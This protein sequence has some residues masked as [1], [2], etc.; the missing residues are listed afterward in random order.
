VYPY[1]GIP[2]LGHEEDRTLLLPLCLI[3]SENGEVMEEGRL[4]TSFGAFLRRF[5][6]EQPLRSPTI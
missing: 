6:Y 5:A 1:E 2:N 3:D 4:R